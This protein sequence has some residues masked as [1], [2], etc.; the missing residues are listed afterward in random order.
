[1]NLEAKDVQFFKVSATEANSQMTL[2]LSG[3]AFHSALAVDKLTQAQ[4]GDTLR[5]TISLVPAR[6]G[7]S[8]SFDYRVKISAA[9]SLVTFGDE[10][11][12]IWEKHL[13][14]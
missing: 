5:L 13:E 2:H 6:P 10:Q 12:V 9:T 3:L 11:K 7:L 1:M 4:D 8:G 14:R